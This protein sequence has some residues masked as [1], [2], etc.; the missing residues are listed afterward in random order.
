MSGLPLVIMCT[1]QGNSNVSNIEQYRLLTHAMVTHSFLGV[2][3]DLLRDM[4]CL[5]RCHAT[6]IDTA[7]LTVSHCQLH[8]ALL[9]E[10]HVEHTEKY[11][12]HAR[13]GK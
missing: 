6:V 10:K 8:S 13:M 3:L 7:V 9:I 5:S 11:M 2:S 12:E 4:G 1:V